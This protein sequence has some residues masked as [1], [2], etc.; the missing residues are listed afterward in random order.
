MRAFHGWGDAAPPC[1]EVPHQRCP[2]PPPPALGCA[3][4]LAATK[5][6]DEEIHEAVKAARE[7]EKEKNKQ[8]PRVAEEGVRSQGGSVQ[9]MGGAACT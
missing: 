6:H 7:E 1:P 9:K 5:K 4:K 8:V 3:D 2:P